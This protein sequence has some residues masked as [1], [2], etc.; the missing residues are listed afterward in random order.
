MATILSSQL[1]DLYTNGKL[2]DPVNNPLSGLA[3]GA[4]EAIV[5]SGHNDGDIYKLFEIP[6]DA[7]P[8]FFGWRNTAITGGT[9]YD[10]GIYDAGDGGAV[11]DDDVF[12]G[13]Q[14]M[15]SASTANIRNAP[16]ATSN[17]ISINTP[18]W[19]LAGDTASTKKN[20]YVI[21]LT[22]DTVGTADGS[23]VV[24]VAYKFSGN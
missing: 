20:T 19:E 7:V 24:F 21:A 12:L 14:S 1:T 17:P 22:A 23:I 11:K 15:A 8:I 16:V 6:G 4:G 13:G 9:A 10:I 3:C 5:A 18:I 2:I